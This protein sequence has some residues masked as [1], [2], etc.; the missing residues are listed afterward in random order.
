MITR[1]K[2][3][4][5]EFCLSWRADSD[6]FSNGNEIGALALNVGAKPVFP[7]AYSGKTLSGK[8]KGKGKEVDYIG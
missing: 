3:L 2:M 1:L 7:A 4:S 8:A 5:S 6:P